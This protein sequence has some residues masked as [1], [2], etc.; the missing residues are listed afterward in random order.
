MDRSRG[1]VEAA[2]A[3][4]CGRGAL[5]DEAHWCVQREPFEMWTFE[6]LWVTAIVW[7]RTE[8]ATLAT[9]TDCCG[10][11]ALGAQPRPMPYIP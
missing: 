1:A 10:L 11:A 5:V 4:G 9:P 7:L 8:R 6:G 2:L 3:A